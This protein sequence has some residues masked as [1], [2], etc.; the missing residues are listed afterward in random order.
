MY[1]LEEYGLATVPGDAF[2]EPKGIR[3]SYAASMD[4]LKVGIKRLREGLSAL[5]DET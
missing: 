4:T 2:G 1:L 5:T 3:I